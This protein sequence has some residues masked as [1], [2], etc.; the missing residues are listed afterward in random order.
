ME[1]WID[2]PM[3][4]NKRRLCNT[5]KVS[6]CYYTADTKYKQLA[7]TSQWW[8]PQISYI[9]PSSPLLSSPLLLLLAGC[10]AGRLKLATKQL[11]SN[12]KNF[13]LLESCD[14][15]LLQSKFWTFQSLIVR[16]C[17]SAK[18]KK[19]KKGAPEHA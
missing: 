15:L 18:K 11:S 5:S 3:N 12:K 10:L 9:V 19:K 8:L 17:S 2:I 14:P 7:T 4:V 1:I 6:L 13:K 16:T